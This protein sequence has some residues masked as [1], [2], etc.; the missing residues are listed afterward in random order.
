[1][2]VC[3]ES[4]RSRYMGMHRL[5][6]RIV[7]WKVWVFQ[8]T[9]GI[10]SII[11]TLCCFCLD[12]QS[13]PT[14]LWLRGMLPTRLLCPWDSPGKNTGVGCHFLLQG[15][16]QTQGSNPSLLHSKADSLLLSHLGSP[17]IYVHILNPH[18]LCL[19]HWQVDSLPLAPSVCS[20]L[21]NH[22]LGKP[23]AWHLDDSFSS[24]FYWKDDLQVGK[25]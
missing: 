15:I 7:I 24:T 20:L 10:W 2:K 12:P 22:F 9:V 25:I 6:L 19:L 13:C 8:I 4:C 14:L 5:R 1:M 3:I 11:R 17:S 21:L 23:K 16:F 18:L